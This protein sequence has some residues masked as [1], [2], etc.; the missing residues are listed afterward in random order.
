VKTAAIHQPNFLPWLGWFDKLDR[1]D[2]FVILD[3]VWL[4]RRS[5]THRVAIL[6]RG[7]A[8]QIAV[9]VQH[10]GSQELPI[11]AARLDHD[12]RRLLKVAQT[13]RHSYSKEPHWK[14]VGAPLVERLLDPPER[15]VDLNLALIGH[16]MG[17]L[18]IDESK[19]RLQSD[20]GGT[21]QKSELMAT[22][23][24]AAGA[25]VYLSG[26]HPP[27]AD[28]AA[29]TAAD[30]NDPAVFAAH[31]VELVYQAFRHPEYA[32]RR[33]PFIPGLSAVDAMV[34]LGGPATLAL[35][36]SGRYPSIE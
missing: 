33:T 28:A 22:L 13:L 20:L 34:R 12:S 35:L 17:Q 29:G 16:L 23:T 15:L 31:G 27:S 25:D 14:A 3:E 8:L 32:Q 26:G 2:V 10:T 7:A 21:G 5:T 18:G 30:Y 6:H 36:R 9:P 1:A 4:N 11:S 24:R 19:L